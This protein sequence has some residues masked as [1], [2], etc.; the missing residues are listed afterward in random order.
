VG[1]CL[2]DGIKKAFTHP[3]NNILARDWYY[4]IKFWNFI[5]RDLMDVCSEARDLSGQTIALKED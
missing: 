3:Y 1:K 4:R 5:S 2:F